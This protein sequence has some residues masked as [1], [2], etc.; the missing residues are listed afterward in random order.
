MGVVDRRGEHKAVRRPGLL[1]KLVHAAVV[2]HTLALGAAA[3]A[4]AIPDGLAAQLDDLIL[5]ALALQLRADFQQ[6]AVGVALG[7]GTSVEHQYLHL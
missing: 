4:D 7:V 2:K 1:H 3:A 6:C 5:H